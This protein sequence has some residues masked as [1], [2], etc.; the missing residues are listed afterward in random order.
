MC[1]FLCYARFACRPCDFTASL[2]RACRLCPSR[3]KPDR[4]QCAPAACGA[5]LKS[6]AK[7]RG[8]A[9]G[10]P[11]RRFQAQ[12]IT[13]GP[14]AGSRHHPPHSTLARGPRHCPPLGLRPKRLRC[15]R[16]RRASRDVTHL[17]ED[18]H[19]LS[20]VPGPGPVHW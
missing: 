14:R 7:P 4:P 19:G 16:L 2:S 5:P 6:L 13:T 8:S 11:R 17:F 15:E 9:Y 10:R 18:S 12:S 20:C 1:A 3:P